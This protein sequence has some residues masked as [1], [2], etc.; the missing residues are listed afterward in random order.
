M[1]GRI[2]FVGHFFLTMGLKTVPEFL[3]ENRFLIKN[4]RLFIYFSDIMDKT[5]NL[6]S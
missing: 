5:D 3:K 6:H 4:I 2:F 1:S